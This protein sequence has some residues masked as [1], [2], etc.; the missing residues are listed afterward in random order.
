MLQ[1]SINK[2]L[3]EKVQ[4]QKTFLR[5]IAILDPD[6]AKTLDLIEELEQ[7]LENSNDDFQRMNDIARKLEHDNET[8]KKQLKELKRIG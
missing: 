6:F 4:C 2:S 7:E 8:L 3:Q 5:K 1:A